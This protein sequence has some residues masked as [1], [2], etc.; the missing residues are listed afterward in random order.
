MSQPT[1]YTAHATVL[2]KLW[3]I[4]YDTPLNLLHF[5]RERCMGEVVYFVIY[6]IAENPRKNKS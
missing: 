3:R 4:S 2:R 6:C 5:K 1:A